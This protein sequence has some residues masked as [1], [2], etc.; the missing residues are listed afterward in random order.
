MSPQPR[1]ILIAYRSSRLRSTGPRRNCGEL[2]MTNWPRCKRLLP[3]PP[4]LERH[5]RK[6]TTNPKPTTVEATPSLDRKGAAV[7][8]G[9]CVRSRN[10]IYRSLGV[11]KVQKVKDDLCKVEFKPSVFS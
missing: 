7:K 5:W 1:A 9:V 2:A 8:S 11:G 4:S 3:R 6:T 10:P